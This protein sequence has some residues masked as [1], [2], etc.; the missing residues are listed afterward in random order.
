LE[1]PCKPELEVR[2]GMKLGEVGVKAE[3]EPL[4]MKEAGLEATR[5][6]LGRSDMILD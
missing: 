2:G 6:N 3:E 4:M 1:W 5:A